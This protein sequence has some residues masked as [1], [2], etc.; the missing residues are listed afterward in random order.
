MKKLFTTALFSVLLMSLAVAT[1]QTSQVAA[2]NAPDTDMQPDTPEIPDKP[3][4]APNKGLS[5]VLP[6]QASPTA[7]N[8][9]NTVDKFVSDPGQG[10]G[11]A[12]SGLL[13]D[14]SGNET[15][16]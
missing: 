11:D 9:L 7:K 16:Q 3:S 1:P 15:E 5:G 8:V 4:T 6:E 12:L 10:L 14:S 2:D 13:G